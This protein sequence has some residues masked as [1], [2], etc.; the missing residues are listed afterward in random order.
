MRALGSTFFIVKLRK[1]FQ[2]I[3]LLYSMKIEIYEKNCPG[4][5]AV[6]DGVCMLCCMP[7]MEAPELMESDDYSCYF[8]RQPSTEEETDRAI[9]AINVSC[10]GAVIYKGQDRKII[11]KILDNKYEWLDIV[12]NARRID[13]WL[14]RIRRL[15]KYG[16]I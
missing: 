15:L 11:H 12:P 13:I 1:L 2:L 14:A 9:E 4:D 7:E 8:K 6:E 3:E 10:C 5:F 16:R